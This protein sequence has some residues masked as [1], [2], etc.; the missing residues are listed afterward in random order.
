MVPALALAAA[1][2][3]LLRAPR[4]RAAHQRMPHPDVRDARILD[5]HRDLTVDEKPDR[6]GRS[7]EETTGRG[8]FTTS[9]LTAQVRSP[10]P[11]ISHIMITDERPE[12]L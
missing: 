2:P 7:P 10:G 5:G 11:S 6:S 8:R 12:R 9:L 1:V 3:A 4:V